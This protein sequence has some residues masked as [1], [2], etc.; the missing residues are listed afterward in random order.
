M[1]KIV[2]TNPCS[3]TERTEEPSKVGFD[4]HTGEGKVESGGQGNLELR[5]SH[6]DGLHTDWRLRECVLEGG[7]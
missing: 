1:K 4:V 7:D 2:P 5:E 3:D 6:D